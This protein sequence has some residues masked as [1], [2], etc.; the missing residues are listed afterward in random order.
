MACRRIDRVPP[1]ADGGRRH[2]EADKHGDESFE[3]SMTVR[4]LLIG[5]G[6]PVTNTENQGDIRDGV[7]QRVNRVGHHRLAV[8]EQTR[9]QL[10]R[11]EYQVDDQPDPAGDSHLGNPGSHGCGFHGRDHNI[12]NLSITILRIM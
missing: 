10:R 1:D 8:S 6:R 3:S 5:R 11:D 7:G 2:R 9:S 12:M 4:V